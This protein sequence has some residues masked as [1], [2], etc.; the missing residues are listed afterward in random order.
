MI[1]SESV[2]DAAR[3]MFVLILYL[4]S[5]LVVQECDESYNDYDAVPVIEI[6]PSDNIFMLSIKINLR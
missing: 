4:Q 3:R 6:K 2:A 5:E 1:C